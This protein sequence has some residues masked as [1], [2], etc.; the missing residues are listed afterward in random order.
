MSIIKFLEGDE[1]IKKQ[2]GINIG[3]LR[4]E[5][6][7]TQEQLAEMVSV[8]PRTIS[9]IEN[10]KN[11]PHSIILYRIADALKVD[12]NTLMKLN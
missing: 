5:K 2:L 4:N 12:Y 10:G 7:L 9:Q 1:A 6:G 3:K 8:S 11:F